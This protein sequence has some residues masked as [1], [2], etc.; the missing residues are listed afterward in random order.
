[1][2]SW[3]W[4]VA[5]RAA[6]V[7]LGVGLGGCA[8]ILDIP[9]EPRFEETGPWRCVG[10]SSEGSVAP[11]E[12]ASV[13]FKVCDFISGCTKSVSGVT[14]K[15]CDKLDV[16]CI[17]PRSA[18]ITDVNGILTVEVPTP[19]GRPFDGYIDVMPPVALCTDQMA[20]G[21]AAGAI[22][23]LARGCNAAS[24]TIP[25][26]LV[27]IYSPVLWFFNPPVVMDLQ[28]PILLQLYPANQLPTLIE[29]AGAEIDPTMASV[30][31]T[32]WD[33]DGNPAAGV[34]LNVPEHDDVVQ[35]LYY[36]TG[37]IRAGLDETDSSGIG[38][39][40]KVP[41]GF[42]NVAGVNEDGTQVGIVGVQARLPYVTYTVLVPPS[43]Q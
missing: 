17:N 6:F 13:S 5:R 38:G 7:C 39:F 40:I 36:N 35:P 1:M 3:N 37:V 15:V 20:F 42:V 2:V 12:T 10:E 14:A 27:P 19:Q 11:R 24:P 25:E 22:C 9:D 4:S 18:P 33:C 32:A 26:C 31:L 43:M 29:A 16:L 21:P 8:Q 34:K 30:F 23:A 28:D 41:P